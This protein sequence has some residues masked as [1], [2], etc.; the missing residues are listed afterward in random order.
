MKR[1]PLKDYILKYGNDSFG[2]RSFSL[3]DQ[4][5]FSVL[6]YVYFENY[7]DMPMSIHDFYFNIVDGKK[8]GIEYREKADLE[9]LKAC[10][11]SK[12]FSDV[13]ICEAV[14]VKS[15]GKQFGASLF[16][17][18]K[19]LIVAYRG[20][21]NSLSGWREDMAMCY[22][23]I[24]PS[25]QEGRTFLQRVM[26]TYSKPVIILGHSKGGTIALYSYLGLNQDDRK[27]V[28]RVFDND[29]PGTCSRDWLDDLDREKV[30]C[31]I[32]DCS[33]I[34]VLQYHL[35]PDFVVRSYKKGM[36]QHDL[37]SWEIENAHFIE[38]KRNPRSLRY[39]NVVNGWIGSFPLDERELF[40]NQVFDVLDSSGAEDFG[41]FPK[42][43]AR[44][45]AVMARKFKAYSWDKR[46]LFWRIFFS[47]LHRIG[48]KPES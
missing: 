10:A 16:D 28:I 12:R 6:S 4:L 48:T 43:A 25:M 38:S 21:D 26:K 44:R 36:F 41:E 17:I 40:C 37:F 42:K 27:R 46:R 45:V 32:P 3:V 35:S 5:V 23:K 15:K 7:L 11:F 30:V 18:G 22:E 39:E 24:V 33:F 2:E 31:I 14:G 8:D 47:L 13:T 34:G 29:G 19:A 1:L 20:T 9:I